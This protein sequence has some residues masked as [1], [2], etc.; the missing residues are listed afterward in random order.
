M[1]EDERYLSLLS[2][3]HYALAALATLFALFP[4]IHLAVGIAFLCGAFK[5]PQG[6]VE[7][8]WVGWIFI[9]FASVWILCGLTFASCVFLTGR[10]LQRK[11]RYMFCLVM[12]GLECVFM[13][14]GTVLGIFTLVVL[15]KDRVRELFGVIDQPAPAR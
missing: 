7:S 10:S 2:I 12:A 6:Q 8:P 3:F 5:D 14:F 1:T 11:R 4:T 13:P 15:L 9:A